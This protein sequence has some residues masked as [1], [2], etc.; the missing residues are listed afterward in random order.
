MNL[1]RRLTPEEKEEEEKR[2]KL[3]AEKT[4]A[5][6][7]LKTARKSVRPFAK[8]KGKIVYHTEFLEIAIISD[9]L[10]E[11]AA[12]SSEL[13]VIG[14]DLEWPFSFQT[15]PGKTATIQIS[16]DEKTCYIFHVSK[17]KNLPKSLS[18]LLIHSN[19]RITGNNIKQDVRKLARDFLGFDGDK[20][21]ENCVDLG[22]LANGIVS[23][24]Q[25]WSL[26]KLVDH[27]LDLRIDKS[28]KIRMSQWHV[29]PLSK[30]QQAYAATDSYVSLVLYTLIKNK[31][32]DMN[33]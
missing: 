11:K 5:E 17:L 30:A 18:E 14:F 26:E 29:I 1:R 33:T 23:T 13:F 19:V 27:F 16:P 21:V 4:V 12:T 3:I 25:R 2:L 10:L 8:F 15:G 6:E 32:I 28:K 20:M 24:T 9:N 22:T 31:E 7:K